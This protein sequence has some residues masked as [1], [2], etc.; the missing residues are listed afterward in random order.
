MTKTSIRKELLTS[1]LKA[2]FKEVG[3]QDTYNPLIIAKFFNPCGPGTWYVTEYEE[4]TGM[5][6][7]YVMG[8][9]EDEWGYVS[10]AELQALRCAPFKLSVERDLYFDEIH[11]SD[12]LEH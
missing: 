9:G 6:V 4:N 2:K 11:F 5:L 10:L 12:L 7:A 3:N 1:E 8:L